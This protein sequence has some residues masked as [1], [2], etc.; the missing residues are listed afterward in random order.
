MVINPFKKEYLI[1]ALLLHTI[2]CGVVSP[3]PKIEENYQSTSE[4]VSKDYSME[5][6]C[7]SLVF[8]NEHNDVKE[9]IV[10]GLYIITDFPQ[11]ANF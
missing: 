1:T 9:N 5:L 10:S 11:V 4:L 7:G 3:E 6:N 2:H 8:F